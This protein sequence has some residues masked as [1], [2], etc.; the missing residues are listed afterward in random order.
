MNNRFI[1]Q[2]LTLLTLLYSCNSQLK[3]DLASQKTITVPLHQ[4]VND[5]NRYVVHVDFERA[6]KV[7]IMVHSNSNSYLILNHPVA[8]KINLGVPLTKVQDYGYSDKGLGLL[9]I[10]YF[11]IGNTI[12][13]YTEKL[14]VFDQG[15]NN[16]LSQGMFGV[17]FLK[18][19]RA[20][21][22]FSKN[23]LT[24]FYPKDSLPNKGLLKQ[25]YQY[26][27]IYFSDQNKGYIMV[28]FD[29]LEKEIPIVSSTVSDEYTFDSDFFG[30][31][32]KLK[33][34]ETVDKSPNHTITPLFNIDRP[35]TYKINGK[36]F[37]YT[38]INK[39]NF[40]SFA[41]YADVPISAIKEHGLLGFDWMKKHSAIMDYSN[42]FLY[43]K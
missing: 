6:H 1:Y 14:P 3:G 25:G 33:G 28:Y 15:E 39:S 34:S 35:F 26:T 19:N 12:I 21:V 43:F 10:K 30:Q 2:C 9:D 7:P 41:T 29:F 4:I 42:S 32:F 20:V 38:A 36:K 17:P 18:E 24:L 13:N 31:Y 37:E 11:K 40:R 5:G 27:K 23:T 8:E 22:N 16:F